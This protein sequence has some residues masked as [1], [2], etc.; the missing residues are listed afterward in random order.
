MSSSSI[1]WRRITS[2]RMNTS[3]PRRPFSSDCCRSRPPILCASR[4]LLPTWVLSRSATATSRRSAHSFTSDLII[5]SWSSGQGCNSLIGGKARERPTAHDPVKAQRPLRGRPYSRDERRPSERTCSAPDFCP[6]GQ[7]SYDGRP[8][9]EITG[10]S[11]G[12]TRRSHRPLLGRAGR[13]RGDN[14]GCRHLLSRSA[15]RPPQTRADRRRRGCPGQ[16]FPAGVSASWHPRVASPGQARLAGD[17]ADRGW[18]AGDRHAPLHHVVLVRPLC[19]DVRAPADPA[20]DRDPAR[21]ADPRRAP[22]P[23]GFNQPP[24]LT[25]FIGTGLLI[26]VILILNYTKDRTPPVVV[27]EPA[28]A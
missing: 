26:V 16:P 6:G 28:A 10:D 25:Q 1:D 17:R 19:R 22:P 21:Q 13:R 18:S 11:A 7:R 4:R 5:W 2:H 24:Y 15:H 23:S 3:S 9:S 12:R 20:V 27:E 8:D 14:V